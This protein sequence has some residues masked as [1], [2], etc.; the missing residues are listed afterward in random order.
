[1]EITLVIIGLLVIRISQNNLTDG[2]FMETFLR[3]VVLAVIV[4]IV[5]V[6]KKKKKFKA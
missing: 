6:V 1:V 2:I 4:A 3:I 5:I